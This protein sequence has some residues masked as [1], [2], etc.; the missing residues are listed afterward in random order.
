MNFGGS[1][2]AS[3]TPR[4]DP[5]P[6][7]SQSFFSKIF[8]DIVSLNS[9]EIALAT[10]ASAVGVTTF[11]GAATS[12]FVSATPAAVAFARVSAPE[13]SAPAGVA[14]E[15]NRSVFARFSDLKRWSSNAPRYA[16]TAIARALVSNSS[17]ASPI[18]YLATTSDS[19]L[20][21]FAAAAAAAPRAVH[22][23]APISPAFPTPTTPTSLNGRPIAAGTRENALDPALPLNS[24][25]VAT[26]WTIAARPF[27]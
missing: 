18:Q 20:A 27:P 23:S 11:G 14:T 22:A 5:I 8:T 26:S 6:S 2:E 9:A 24:S 12:C 21:L 7:F 15:I 4:N 13:T 10:S 3:E 17:G 16:P 19:H 25:A 1:S